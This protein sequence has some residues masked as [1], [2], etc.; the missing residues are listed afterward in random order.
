[1]PVDADKF[2]WSLE[3]VFRWKTFLSFETIKDFAVLGYYFPRNTISQ[4]DREN[5][6]GYVGEI[7]S[8]SK[9]IEYYVKRY[10][11]IVIE[12][13]PVFYCSCKHKVCF[14]FLRNIMKPIPHNHL[15]LYL[16]TKE[17]KWKIIIW[18][19]SKQLL[20]QFSMEHNYS[21]FGSGR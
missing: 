9:H 17:G 16:W 11:S 5:G 1:M 4:V 8:H 21:V 18:M 10:N 3:C 19:L 15:V 2:L 6:R 7:G 12:Q 14:L 13:E 20:R